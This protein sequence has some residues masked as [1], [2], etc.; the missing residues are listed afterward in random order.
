LPRV[1]FEVSLD[2]KLYIEN[3]A[4][5]KKGRK[6]VLL[7]PGSVWETKKWGNDKFYQLA[8]ILLEQYNVVLVGSEAD[9]FECPAGVTNLCG[10][11]KL[12]QLFHLFD[13]ADAVVTNDSA[14]THIAS[15]TNT[16]TIA[17]FGP[18]HPM[19]GFAPLA[20]KSVVVQ[21]E[22]LKCRPCRVH[23]SKR[24]PIGTHECMTSISPTKI[25]E[26]LRFLLSYS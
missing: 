11:T 24:C 3:I 20:D 18:T 9:S 5:I 26:E 2:D 17:I 6:T 4:N 12:P 8:Q 13:I 23:G 25:A 14:P 7:N 1:D 19:F 15:I 21:N 10:K 22:N 16:P